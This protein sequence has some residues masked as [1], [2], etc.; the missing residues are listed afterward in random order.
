MRLG[1]DLAGKLGHES[2]VVLQRIEIYDV[3]VKFM[4]HPELCMSWTHTCLVR[5][6]DSTKTP[7][8]S[9]LCRAM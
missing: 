1:Q 9:L 5:K 2:C 3:A 6:V 8:A 4:A 7:M